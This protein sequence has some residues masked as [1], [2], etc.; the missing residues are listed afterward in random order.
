MPLLSPPSIVP[1]LTSYDVEAS[2]RLVSDFSSAQL[3]YTILNGDGSTVLL[4]WRSSDDSPIRLSCVDDEATCQYEIQVRA[5]YKSWA[6]SP[7]SSF[8]VFINASL[9]RFPPHISGARFSSSPF[10]HSNLIGVINHGAAM[11]QVSIERPVFDARV[12]C[13]FTADGSQVTYTSLPYVA[14]FIVSG[15]ETHLIRA[16]CFYSAGAT[17]LITWYFFDLRVVGTVQ[18]Q[19]PETRASFI[20]LLPA[21]PVSIFPPS[22]TF[23][24]LSVLLN[25]SYGAS[26][27]FYTLDGS[28][29]TLPTSNRYSLLFQQH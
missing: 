6:T 22:G 15:R 1:Q 5:E 4:P 20:I 8:N 14:P 10:I 19:S 13:R 16:K 27:L 28:D 26:S 7:I 23:P 9:D 2:L 21:S 18:L 25:S 17:S 11:A 3:L 24:S 29:P 12:V